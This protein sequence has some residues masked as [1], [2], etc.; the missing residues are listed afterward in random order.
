MSP[1][2][3]SIMAAVPARRAGAGSAMNDATR[4]LGA[5]L[6]IAVLGSIAAS[7]YA[8]KV[9]PFLRGLSPADRSAARTSIA[10]ALRV[11]STLPAAGAARAHRGR[12]PGLR[13]RDPS[14][15]DGRRGPRA[16]QC[17]DRLPL[18]PALAR[19]GSRA[20]VSRR[21]RAHRRAR[22]GGSRARSC[23][24]RRRIVAGRSARTARREPAMSLPGPGRSD[25]RRS[26]LTRLVRCAHG[27]WAQTAR[28]DPQG[29]LDPHGRREASGVVGERARC[30]SGTSRS[31]WCSTPATAPRC[32][33]RCAP[34]HLGPTVFRSTDMGATWTEA[35]A[36][37]RVR[38]GRS[39][40]AQ[41]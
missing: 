14:R 7:R 17:G 36:P 22:R 18:P 34:G 37:A 26:C 16:H 35:I 39:A 33:S 9:A 38:R 19:S 41:R 28:R 29:G 4:E 30:S 2:T 23:D 12:R 6:G 32:W 31:T 10:G 3:A 40:R 21:G 8:N 25:P 13:Q 27:G 20:P 1:M 24:C 15:G 11:A 5:A